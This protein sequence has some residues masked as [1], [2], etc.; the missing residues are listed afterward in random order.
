M[1]SWARFALEATMRLQVVTWSRHSGILRPRQ[2]RTG[3]V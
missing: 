3:A 1:S 2:D